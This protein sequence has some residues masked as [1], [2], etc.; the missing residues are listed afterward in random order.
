MIDQ[1]S[2]LGKL[3]ITA[4]TVGND[5]GFYMLWQ[6]LMFDGGWWARSIMKGFGKRFSILDRYNLSEFIMI[7]KITQL[8]PFCHELGSKTVDTIFK[9]KHSN[10]AG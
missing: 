3:P 1:G 9:A 5:G 2:R 6:S 8:N 10:P 7:R 4:M